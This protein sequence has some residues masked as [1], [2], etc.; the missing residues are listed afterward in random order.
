MIPSRRTQPYRQ[1]PRE[2]GLALDNMLAGRAIGQMV[3]PADFARQRMQM[4]SP[5]A[6]ADVRGTFGYSPG[7][8]M[9]VDHWGGQATNLIP[10]AVHG[11]QQQALRE[12][13]LQQL[14]KQ[15]RPLD[16]QALLQQRLAALGD[17]PALVR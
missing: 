10:R 6:S 14:M 3:N 11:Q 5:I 9:A 15:R 12:L 4:A 17:A 7:G 8:G 13:A 2:A 1:G 16:L